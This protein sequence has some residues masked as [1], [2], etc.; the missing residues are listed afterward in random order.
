MPAEQTQD[1]ISSLLAEFSTRLNEV[2]EKQRLLRDRALLIGENLISTKEDHELQSHTTKKE[3]TQINSEIKQLK[4][5]MKRVI[6]E[7]ENFARKTE[8]DIL[9]KQSQ[10]FQPLKLARIKDV[11][12]MIKEALDKNTSKK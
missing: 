11:E 5:L 4:V 3:I 6:D 2:E 7:L 10:M 8:L 1:P 9:K 12:R